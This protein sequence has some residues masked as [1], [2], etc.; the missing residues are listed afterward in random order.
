MAY[1]K[2]KLGKT[3][4]VTRGQGK[5]IP[6]IFL[7][8]G[9]GGRHDWNLPVLGLGMQ[10]KVYLY[11]QLGGGKSGCT[12]KKR[13]NIETFVAELSLLVKKW[14]LKE[15]HLAGTSW[16]ATLALEYYFRERGHGVR[17]LILSSP[18]VSASDW[19]SDAQKLIAQLPEHTR[20][21][22]EY[23]HEIE[24]TD[25]KVYQAA[26]M[27]FYL[28]HVLRNKKKLEALF[29]KFSASKSTGSKIYSH[30]WGPSEFKPTGTLKTY[31]RVPDL[32]KITVPTLFV[33]GEFDEATP[34]TVKKYS[35]LVS[36]SRFEVLPGC[37]HATLAEN[38]KLVLKTMKN[39]LS[40][41]G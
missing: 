32:H 20:K 15:F 37:S 29:K 21:V 12:D 1:V 4:Y 33:C 17:S 25:A 41:L 16:G 3:F 40:N 34:A 35:E 30:M 28:K 2:H 10:R 38:P 26:M 9:P 24:A 18:L 14:G 11:D 39:F 27:E 22:I 36:G 5:G 7:H 31:S 23:C 13:W 6:L 19:E 8:G